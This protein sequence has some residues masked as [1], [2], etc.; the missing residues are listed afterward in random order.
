MHLA[1]ES[2]VDSQLKDQNI[3]KTNILG[4]YNT[5]AESLNC[6]KTL[7]G[8]DKKILDFIMSLPTKYLVI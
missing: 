4:T 3:L 2:H 8:S 6:Y 1:A 5:I 7:K